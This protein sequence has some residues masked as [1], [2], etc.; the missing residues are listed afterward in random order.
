MSRY[1]EVWHGQRN[2][3]EGNDSVMDVCIKVIK[4]KGVH[5]VGEC[6]HHLQGGLFD[7]VPQ[8][9]Y[10]DVA[11]WMKLNHP[12]ILRCFGV[13]TDKPQIVMEWMPRRAAMNY[14]QKDKRADRICLVSS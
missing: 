13:T 3:K 8:E 9:F 14:V 1:A 5:K 6:S 4:L 2:P 11:L 12:N 7:S 10:G